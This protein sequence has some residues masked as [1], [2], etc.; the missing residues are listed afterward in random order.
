MDHENFQ[1]YRASLPGFVCNSH[2]K[3]GNVQSHFTIFLLGIIRISCL[4][5]Q[6]LHSLSNVRRGGSPLSLRDWQKLD[7]LACSE[8]PVSR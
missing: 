3:S 4:K 5:V 8:L 7:K 6:L 1:P 2:L